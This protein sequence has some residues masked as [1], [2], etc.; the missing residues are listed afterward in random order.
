MLESLALLAV[1]TVV[2]SSV[3]VDKHPKED[4]LAALVRELVEI[5]LV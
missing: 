5:G 1:Q 2:D 3:G 4:S